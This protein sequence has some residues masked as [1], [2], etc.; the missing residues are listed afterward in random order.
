[1]AGRKPL[2]SLRPNLTRS[3]GSPGGDSEDPHRRRR[4]G[5]GRPRDRFGKTWLSALDTTA[6]NS[7]G[8]SSSRTGKRSSTRRGH[9]PW[10]PSLGPP[11]P[12]H[13]NRKEPDADVLFASIQTLG[14][15][16]HLERLPARRL[17]LHRR[18]RVPPRRRRDLPAAHRALPPEV[19]A[20]AHRHARADRRGRSP[21]PLR[22]EPRVPLRSDRGHSA[23]VAFAFPYFGVP[24]EVDYANIPGV[25]T[26]DEE[27]LTRRSP[28]RRAE[29]ALEQYRSRAGKRHSLLRVPAARGLH[30]GVLRKERGPRC[31]RALGRIERPRARSLER[32]ESGELDVVAQWTSSTKA[33]TCP[34]LTR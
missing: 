4:R 1:M 9:H 26:F 11:R 25:P 30:G 12:V 10:G 23:R 22:G 6:R 19:P 17:R 33:S 5:A 27:A 18:G 32:L 3:E 24:D 8:C 34:T 2:P 29:N 21:R 14:R 20:R 31:R 28:L 16:R 7:A 15:R 13:R